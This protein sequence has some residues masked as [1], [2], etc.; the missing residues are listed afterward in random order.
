[1]HLLRSYE[2]V[3]ATLGWLVLGL[4]VVATVDQVRS[5]GYRVLFRDSHVIRPPVIRDDLSIF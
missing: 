2:F 1:M 4:L 3:N 5:G